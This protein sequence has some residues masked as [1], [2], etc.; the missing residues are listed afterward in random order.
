[1][2]N[3]SGYFNAN[4]IARE[5]AK[6]AIKLYKQQ[7]RNDI[8][9]NRLH[10]T[11]LLLNHYIDF[12]DHYELIKYKSSDIINEFV[13]DLGLSDLGMNEQDEV[14]IYSIKR[15]KIRT[16][17]MISQIEAAVCIVRADMKERNEI[18]K[19]KAF[20]L[21]YMDRSKKNI[22]FNQKV[23]LVAEQMTAIGMPCSD[24]S[25]RRWADEILNEVSVKL[26]GVDGLRLDI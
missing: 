16:K 23:K 26:F 2:G 10:N 25:V 4:D 6:E 11:G 14:Y 5:A 24:S 17:I 13:D 7:E 22:K 15:S 21:L 12:L 1:L 19:I 3:K 20:E 8:K 18:E 9:K